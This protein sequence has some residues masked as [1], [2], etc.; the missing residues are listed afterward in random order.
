M[1]RAWAYIPHAQ[2][3]DRARI[4]H[5]IGRP[6]ESWF[7]D[8]SK[9]DQVLSGIQGGDLLIVASLG[10]LGSTAGA[11][12]RRVVPLLQR[13]V[14]IYALQSRQTIRP[15]DAPPLALFAGLQRPSRQS[16]NGPA[17]ALTDADIATIRERIADGETPKQIADDLGVHRST[18]YRALARRI[19]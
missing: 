17:P 19:P 11:A 18:L 14:T 12:L 2:E 3:G 10:D 5:Q 1:N 15:A 13:S 6:L 16:S 4:E 7:D 8:P 9:R